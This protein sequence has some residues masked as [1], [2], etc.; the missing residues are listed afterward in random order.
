MSSLLTRGMRA[1]AESRLARGAALLAGI[2]VVLALGVLGVGHGGPSTTNLD[3]RYLYLAGHY[4]RAGTNAYAPTIALPGLERMGDALHQYNFAYPP[5]M[6]PL[7]LL[8][9]L[10]S[11]HLSYLIMDAVNLGAIA[12]LAWVG[13]RMIEEPGPHAVAPSRSTAHRWFVPALVAGNLSTAFAVWMGQTTLLVAAV[14][15]GAWYAARRERWV[16]AGLLLAI[17]TFKPPLSLFVVL[18]FVLERRW[19]ALMVATATI[20]LFAALPMVVVG[21]VEVWLEWL[22]AVGRYG[23]HEYNAVGTRMLFNLRSL[24]YAVGVRVPDLFALGFVA[25]GILW[26]LRHRLTDR[27]VLGLLLGTALIFGYGHSYDLAALVVLIPLFWRHLHQRPTASLVALGLLVAI[28]FPNSM[29]ERF[30][31]DVLLHARVALVAGALGWLAALSASEAEAE[32]EGGG[33]SG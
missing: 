11:L 12:V 15:A 2:A 26:W 32:A 30:Q 3:T 8:L 31:S 18:W 20:L 17:G 21:P 4:W 19:R 23:S 25:T 16:T 28:A 10:G 33:S 29:L 22:R 6:T 5:Q 24:L 14:L 9:A 7:C 1:L 27:D 13:V